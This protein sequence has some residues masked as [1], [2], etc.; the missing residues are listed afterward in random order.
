MALENITELEQA[1]GIEGGKLQEMITSEEV[2]K[3]DLSE[4]IILDKPIYDERISNI[5]KESSQQALEVAIKEQRN[6]LGLEFQ[7]KTMENL[8]TALK[9]KV[10]AES[11]V[12]PET[13]YKNLKSDFEKLQENLQQKET[14][15]VDFKTNIQKKQELNEIKSEFTKHIVGETFVSKST[16]FTEAKEKGYSFEKEE[17]KIVVKDA[18]GN[19]LKDEK[20]LSPI[21]VK[22]FVSTFVTPYIKPTTGG[23]GGKDESDTGKAGSLEAFLKEAEKNGWNATKQNE[24]MSK[25][26]KDGTLKM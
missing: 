7:G 21:A 26:I 22:D 19:V 2:H 14:E 20:T 5:K 23:A 12:E 25:R 24:E 6:A 18:N 1:L 11:K 16:I 17:G 4:K 8:V 13:K 9:A 15:F 3:I 10:E